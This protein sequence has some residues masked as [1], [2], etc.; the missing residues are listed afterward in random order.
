MK[1]DH[2]TNTG[3]NFHHLTTLWTTHWLCL[4]SNKNNN[5]KTYHLTFLN[6]YFVIVQKILFHFNIYI[7][8]EVV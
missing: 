3:Q 6:R 4:R 8:Y 7:Y 1:L 5:N 2:G